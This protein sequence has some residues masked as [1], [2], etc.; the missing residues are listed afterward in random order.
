MGGV[1]WADRKRT[2]AR[3]FL[4]EMRVNLGRGHIKRLVERLPAKLTGSFVEHADFL[5]RLECHAFRP[6]SG[7]ERRNNDSFF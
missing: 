3:G 2:F 7:P 1:A 5:R 6:F 4:Y